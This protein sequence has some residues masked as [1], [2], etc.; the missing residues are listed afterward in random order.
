[1]K[2][3]AVLRLI[4]GGKGHS[5]ACC[6]ESLGCKIALGSEN[7]HPVCILCVNLLSNAMSHV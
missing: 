4:Y 7:S 6:D 1:M 2:S 5:D 3:S